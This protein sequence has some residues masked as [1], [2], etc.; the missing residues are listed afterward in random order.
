MPGDYVKINNIGDGRFAILEKLADG[1]VGDFSTSYNIVYSERGTIQILDSIWDFSKSNYAYDIAS[2]EETLYDQLPD[3]EL[4]YILI[5]LKDDIFVRDLKVNWN[6]FFFKAVKYA[7]TEQKLLDWAFKTSFIT[8]SN[9]I[10]ELTQPSVYRIDNEE[11]FEEYIKEVKPYRTKIRSYTSSYTAIDNFGDTW[12]TTTD[13]DLPSY[14]NSLTNQYEVVTLD[15]NL[16]NESPWKWWFNNYTCYV[17]RIEVGHEG[18]GY[19]QTPTVVITT[20]EGDEGSG[21]TAEAYI[22][23]GK[24]YSILVTNPGSGYVIPPVI[25][26]VGG[27][28]SVTS[29]ATASAVMANDTIRKNLIEMKFDRVSVSSEINNEEVTYTFPPCSGVDNKFVLPWLASPDK[30]TIV[31]LLD[32]KL[33]LSTDYTIEYYTE[34]GDTY[35]KHRCRFVFLNYVPTENQIFKITYRKNIDL[36]TAVDRITNFYKPT[37]DMPGLELPL[38]MSGAENGSR[39]I[40][41]LSFGYSP[42]WGQGIYDTNTV[43]ADLVDYY[44]SVKLVSNLTTGTSTLTVDS[45]NGIVV[46]QRVTLSNTSTNYFRPNTVVTSVN[47]TAST[48]TISDARYEISRIEVSSATNESL[49]Y[50]VDSFNTYITVGDIAIISGTDNSSVLSNVDGTYTVTGVGVDKFTATKSGTIT[51]SADI[52]AFNSTAS[53]YIPSVLGNFNSSSTYRIA[54][55]TETVSETPIAIFDIGTALETVSAISVYYTPTVGSPSFIGQTPSAVTEWYSLT[56]TSSGTYVTVYNLGTAVGNIHTFDISVYSYPALEL[57]KDN[58]VASDLDTELSAG[59]WNSAGEF[60]GALGVNPTDVLVNGS[61]FLNP[62]LGYAPEELVKGQTLESV[63]ISVYTQNEDSSALAV[64]GSYPVY[65]NKSSIIEIGQSL[66]D[67]VGVMV[68]YN[69]KVLT[70]VTNPPNPDDVGPYYSIVNI[71]P[72]GQGGTTFVNSEVL[73]QDTFLGPYDLGFEWNMYGET[74]SQVYIGSNGYLTFGS[75]ALNLDSFELTSLPIPAIF[76]MSTDLW[77]SYGPLGQGLTTGEVPGFYISTGTVENSNFKFWR[78]MFL[79]SLADYALDSESIILPTISFEVTLYSDGDA[80]QYVEIVYSILPDDL[81]IYYFGIASANGTQVATMPDTP[82]NAQSYVYY[83]KKIDGIW[84][85]VGGGSFDTYKYPY[86]F[87]GPDQYFIAGGTLIVAPQVSS[88][89]GGY[90]LMQMGGDYVIDSNM[91]VTSTSTALVS[92]SALIDNVKSVLVTVDGDIIEEMSSDDDYGYKIT[93]TGSAN[94]R[95]AVAVY[96]IPYGYHTVQA[97]FLKSNHPKFNRMY[98]DH[99]G[100]LESSTANITLTN[101]PGVIE[102][103]SSQVIVEQIINGDTRRLKPPPCSYYTIQSD[104]TIFSIDDNFN[105]PSGFYNYENVKVYGNGV[106]LRPGFDYSLDT[107]S[108]SVNLSA[109]LLVNGDSLVIENYIFNDY[110]IVGNLLILS[111]PPP[112]EFSLNVISFTDHDNMAI[113]T[114]VFPGSLSHRFVLDIPAISED[115]VW[116]YINGIP[117]SAGVDYE[118]LEDLRTVQIRTWKGLQTND[119]VIITSINGLK[120]SNVVVGYR[121]FKDIFDRVQYTRIADSNSTR[122]SKELTFED[123]EIHVYDSSRLIPPNP[124]K[125]KPGVVFIDSER[126][127]F[128]EKKNNILSNL[129]RSTMGTGPAKFSEIGTKVVDQSPQQYILSQDAVYRQYHITSSTVDSRVL[130]T[131]TNTVNTYTFVISTSG[132]T[133]NTGTMYE[134]N[135]DGIT[136]ST[137]TTLLSNGLTIATNQVIVKY[138]GRILRKTTATI[139]DPLVSYDLIPESSIILQPE[140][141]VEYNTMTGYHELSL[142]V[143]GFNAG[144]RVDIEQKVGHT[145]TTGSDSILTSD[146]VQA[147][148]L[149]DRTTSLPDS[150]YYGGSPVLTDDNNFDLTDDNNNPL[151]GY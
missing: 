78:L 14:F 58:F 128:F 40:Q 62:E 2:L 71:G 123:S 109:G 51:V 143:D 144:V 147:K 42:V 74:S 26:I 133:I 23:R 114:E 118:L 82:A 89:R 135:G 119:E 50:T 91:V 46:G 3:L 11:S 97:W 65:N 105:R 6:L 87:T 149:R 81:P 120:S 99:Y 44:T 55:F 57:W 24:L 21:A 111:S 107:V 104:Q 80:H 18:S 145:W 139:H 15:N 34:V 61:S 29:V 69:G 86:S 52:R 31:P 126:I 108:N 48:I 36:Y 132:Y 113:H 115:Y 16:M 13:F 116:V 98:S 124:Y 27:G 75:G 47:S 53:V 28:A 106:L 33:V 72:R 38:L 45:T 142:T 85:Y 20:A 19:T 101:P 150:E 22:R 10:G 83:S 129:R 95:A 125:N 9:Q 17:G 37:D 148:F 141:I 136:L 137:D 94:N 112:M 77:Q 54:A 93:T 122:L 79:G 88:G 7:L 64:T 39:Q 59:S 4:S 43:W 32:G 63:G 151:E 117:L 12:D 130:T 68:H 73:G 41:G 90:T 49:F 131:V 56:E 66:E 140:F 127:E 35:T 110:V 146:S 84:N 60:V 70:R 96:N 5:A 67:A 100:P 76:M 121:I 92:S 103:V 138:G 8:I 30:T 1:S 102:P 134:S 25:T